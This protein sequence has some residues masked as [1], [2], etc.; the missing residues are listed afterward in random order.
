MDKEKTVDIAVIISGLDEEYQYNMICGINDF[1]KGKNMNLAYFAAFGGMLESRRYDIGE[2]SIYG[3]INFAAFDGVIFLSNTICDPDVRK[4]IAE[5]LSKSGKPA[6]VFDCDDYPSFYNIS[7]DNTSAMREIV[8]HVICEHGARTINFIS[9]PMSNPE[10]R[11]RLSA[12]REVMEENGLTP[13]EAR[14]YYGEFRSYDGKAAIEHFASS[15]LS[16]PDAFICANDAMALTAM[17][18][19]E[20]LGYRIPEDVIVTGFDNTYNARNYTPSLTS[21]SRPLYEAGQKACE[22]LLDIIRGGNPEN[23][24][25]LEASPVFTES[26]GCCPEGGLDLK[27]Y[28]KRIYARL[29]AESD[30][31]CKLNILTARLAESETPEDNAERIKEFVLELGCTHFAL[32][33]TS[34]WQDDFNGGEPEFSLAGGMTAPLIVHDGVVS[35][36]EYF[37]GRQMYPDNMSPTGLIS[38]FLPLHFRENVLGYYIMTGTDFPL[39]S[40]HCHTFSMNVSNS[41]ENVRKLLHLNRA[42]EELN[43]LYV[44]DPLTG[45]YNRNGF[46]NKVDGLFR[47]CASDH[48]SVMLTFIDMDGLKSINDNYGHNEGDFAIQRLAEVIRECCRRDSVCARFG[49]D[50]FI[51]FDRNVEDGEEEAMERRF[52]AKIESINE[53]VNKPYTISASLGTVIMTV[54]E[55]TTLYNVIRSADEKMYDV[56]KSKKTTRPFGGKVIG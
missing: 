48:T 9:G 33:L 42:M 15:G 38:Y 44:I 23:E 40:L 43:R 24:I 18:A 53:M 36:R 14:I 5:R 31:T 30:K 28:K 41:I 2:Y 34:D 37:S 11:E 52:N 27:E 20:K 13:E 6:V 32:C 3:L 1:A 7:I 12:F 54:D 25:R 45:I 4:R 39:G 51:I 19:L 26:C 56:K 16:L 55:D 49:G 50:E 17:S 47:E 35:S 22:L 46:I 8:R 21:V 29:E 10:A